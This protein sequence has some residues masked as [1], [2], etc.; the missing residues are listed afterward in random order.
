M[1]HEVQK[2]QPPTKAAAPKPKSAAAQLRDEQIA[3]D[4]RENRCFACFHAP[5]TCL[6]GKGL[7]ASREQIQATL[8]AVPARRRH[9]K[10]PG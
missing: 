7:N 9:A 5:C 1:H 2:P 4:A 10:Q 6:P 8:S 3:R